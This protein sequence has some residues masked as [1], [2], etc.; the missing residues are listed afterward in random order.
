VVV[1]LDGDY[2]YRPST[3]PI[4]LAPIIEGRA[5]IPR[6]GASAA[7]ATPV[8][9]RGTIIRIACRRLDQA[10]VRREDQSDLGPF[11]LAAQMCCAPGP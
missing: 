3:L 5:D 2:M 10:F 8:R 1:F 7:K 9:Y 4:I 6:F 11:A